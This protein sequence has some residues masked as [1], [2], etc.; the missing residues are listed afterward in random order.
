MANVIY[1]GPITEQPQTV[2]KPVA[3]AYLPGT[4][5]E[6]TA[7][8]LAQ[9]TTATA[10]RPMVLTNNWMKDQDHLTAYTSGDTG[11]AYLAEPGQT[12]QIAMANATYT[13]GQELT[14]AASGRCAAA[15]SGNIV[16]GWFRGTAGAV[17]AGALVDVEIAN[18]YVKA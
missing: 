2:N 9:I 15:G 18:A 3:G 7:T 4:W 11:I 14:I 5:V 12:Y 8:T 10:K 1:R 17:T 16:I 6:E 13:Y